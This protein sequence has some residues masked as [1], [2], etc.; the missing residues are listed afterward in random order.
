M[1][2]R[3]AQIVRN[4]SSSSI[5][6]QHFDSRC[7]KCRWIDGDSVDGRSS[8]SSISITS[9][10]IVTEPSDLLMNGLVNGSIVSTI[11]SPPSSFQLWLIRI[12]LKEEMQE[13]S[14]VWE[15]HDLI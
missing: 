5:A 11:C 2:R 10:S 7:T 9:S 6:T 15:E 1:R 3:C 12:E 13:R 4:T 8:S 14:A